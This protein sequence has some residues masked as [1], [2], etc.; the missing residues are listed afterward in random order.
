M[1][2]SALHLLRQE[3]RPS[4]ERIRDELSGNICRCTGYTGIVDAVA[5]AAGE[6]TPAARPT[7]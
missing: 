1:L 4:R 7:G 3:P 2:M 5:A 6:M